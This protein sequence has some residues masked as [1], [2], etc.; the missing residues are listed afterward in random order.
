MKTI[1]KICPTCN[2][3][4][5]V[6]KQ[7]TAVNAK[8]RCHPCAISDMYVKRGTRAK[9][10]IKTC[11]TCKTERTVRSYSDKKNAQ[12]LT[13]MRCCRISESRT[14]TDIAGLITVINS[15]SNF[16]G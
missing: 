8:Q 14:R 4:R 2:V 7:S 11:P 1:T 3:T 9:T 6:R 13:C 12:H 10:I 15:P 16:L 5:T